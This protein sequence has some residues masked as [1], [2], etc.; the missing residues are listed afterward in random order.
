MLGLVEEWGAWFY[1]VPFVIF[2][3]IYFSF[4]WHI[5]VKNLLKPDLKKR[6]LKRLAKEQ[7][8]RIQ[9]RRAEKAGATVRVE[10]KATRASWYWVAQGAVYV[11]FLVVLGVFSA[12]PSYTYMG[13]G[14]A[15]IK[16]S[17]SH[18]G[19][20]VEPCTERTK[21]ELSKLAPNMRSKQ[22]CSRERH[23]ITLELAMDGNVIYAGEAIPAGLRRD[24]SSSFYEKFFVSA[25]KHT[26]TVRM[27]DGDPT[28]D[29]THELTQVVEVEPT[30]N[31]VIGFIEN[32]HRFYFR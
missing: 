14:E 21:A 20:R 26:F 4:V 19:Q 22:K 9:Q 1:A 11:L 12:S 25:G 23:V 7:E 24:G 10:H 17:L 8:E 16:L 3:P 5:G 30:Q 2:A 27:N 28:K 29:Y 13:A 32:D 15:Q 31:M 18:P 6:E